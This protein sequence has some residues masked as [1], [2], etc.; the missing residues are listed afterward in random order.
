MCSGSYFKAE[1]QTKGDLL[2]IWQSFPDCFP[3]FDPSHVVK[4]T[5]RV[6]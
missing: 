1:L 4:K 2:V 5:R 6:V 3:C